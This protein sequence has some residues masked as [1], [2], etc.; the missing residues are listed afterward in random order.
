[1]GFHFGNSQKPKVQAIYSDLWQKFPNNVMSYIILLPQYSMS[2]YGGKQIGHILK[3]TAI[4]SSEW[5]RFGTKCYLTLI[6]TASKP[7]P[8][9]L[10]RAE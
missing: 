2:F 5:A 7:Y 9:A 1:M 6:L 3:Y 4:Q 10:P 8:N